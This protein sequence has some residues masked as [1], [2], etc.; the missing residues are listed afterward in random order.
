MRR[1][2]IVAA[3][4]IA[5]ATVG[6]AALPAQ[7][8]GSL[9]ATFSKDSDWGSGYQGK[10]TVANA[11]GAT[12]TGWKVEFDLPAGSTVGTYWDALLT[13][14]GGHYPFTNR[15]YNGTLANGASARVGFAV[16]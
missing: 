10:Y 8:A 4:L 1:L 5:A 2:V 16:S 14:S 6:V 15:Q 9:T 7:A 13:S 11:T 3:L 12:V